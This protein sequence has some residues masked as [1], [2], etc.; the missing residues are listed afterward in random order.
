L[1][2]VPNVL[3]AVKLEH[4]MTMVMISVVNMQRRKI[5]KGL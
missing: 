3:M 5:M 4:T 1:V 2:T